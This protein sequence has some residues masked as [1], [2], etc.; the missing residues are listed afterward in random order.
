MNT[1]IW[2]GKYTVTWFPNNPRGHVVCISFWHLSIVRAQP[3][4]LQILM[5]YWDPDT[6]T[7][8]IDGMPLTL[9]VEDIYFITGLS[10]QGEIVNLRARGVGGGHTIDEYI[11]IYSFPDIENFGS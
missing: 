3:R 2:I 6:E 1:K 11:V 5:D 7:F 10:R 9:E 8:Q 4:L